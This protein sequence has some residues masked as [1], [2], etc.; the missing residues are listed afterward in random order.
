ML[1]KQ[2]IGMLV[3]GHE[4]DIKSGKQQRN[5]GVGPSLLHLLHRFT[6]NPVTDGPQ[7]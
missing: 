1:A 2:P 7:N 4:T 3:W 5:G 6:L